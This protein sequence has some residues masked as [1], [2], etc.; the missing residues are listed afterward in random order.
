[1]KMKPENPYQLHLP[2][3]NLMSLFTFGLISIQIYE[4]EDMMQNTN[5]F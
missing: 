2:N 3:K 5:W 4:V 1:M